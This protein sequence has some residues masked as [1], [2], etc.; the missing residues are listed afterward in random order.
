MCAP[1]SIDSAYPLLFLGDKVTTDH[2]SPAGSIARVS[3][4]AKYLQS[5]RWDYFNVSFRYASYIFDPLSEWEVRIIIVNWFIWTIHSSESLFSVLETHALHFCSKIAFYYYVDKFYD[6]DN[7]ML[8]LIPLYIWFSLTP[9]EFNSYGARRGNDAVMTRGTFASI[10]LQNRLIGKTGP[11][12][13]HIPTGQTVSVQTEP[14]WTWFL[15]SLSS[16]FGLCCPITA[17]C[18]W[19]CWTLSER[20]NSPHHPGRKRV[21]LWQLTRLGRQ[22]TL[23]T[24]TGAVI[25]FL[26]KCLEIFC[27]TNTKHTDCLCVSQ[28][29]R[30]VIAESFE[31]IHKNHLVG[32]GI[33]PLQFLPGQNA[34]SL[35]LCGKE[36]FTINIPQELT[37]RQQLTVQV[38]RLA[39][40]KTS[41]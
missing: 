2:I 25:L 35:E 6:K 20:W 10:K 33:A 15:L 1:Q 4:A 29:V 9:R 34:D 30:A 5:K 14:V 40:D 24:G 19:S 8:S 12:T 18:V 3:A 17:G 39:V 38:E 27:Y 28:G 21:R 16:W 26:R 13:L 32:M 11:K 23:F 41:L 36:R 22:R 37:P 7:Q 31:K